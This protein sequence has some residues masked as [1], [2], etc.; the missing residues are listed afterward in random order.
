MNVVS[1]FDKVLIV[2]VMIEFI[3]NLG[4][5]GKISFY[6]VLNVIFFVI[7]VDEDFFEF[8]IF[9]LNCLLIVVV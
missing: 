7:G 5:L 8:F 2:L 3:Y 6:M 9:C 4:F 1:D